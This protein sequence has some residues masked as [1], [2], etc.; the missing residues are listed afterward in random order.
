[1]EEAKD[2][3]SQAF[4]TPGGPRKRDIQGCEQRGASRCQER[5]REKISEDMHLQMW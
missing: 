2:L 5:S 1:M 4:F 3:S